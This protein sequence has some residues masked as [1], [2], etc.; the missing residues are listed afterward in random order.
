MNDWT[1]G[2]LQRDPFGTVSSLSEADCSQAQNQSVPSLAQFLEVAARSGR[3]VI[4][5]LRRPPYGHPYHQSYIN[6]TLQ[7]VQAHINSSQV[8]VPGG[9]TGYYVEWQVS[10]NSIAPE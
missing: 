1:H 6:I 4:F 5:D 3:L 8:S 10:F 7:V 9:W 2:L